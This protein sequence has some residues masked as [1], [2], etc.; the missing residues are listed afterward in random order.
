MRIPGN[1]LQHLKDFFYSEL[2]G[3]YERAEIESMFATAAEYYLGFS[4]TEL[5][6]KAGENLNQSDVLKLYD[7][8]K[9]LKK[10]SPLQYILGSVHFYDTIIQVNS[11]VL[12]PRPETEE[13][14]DIIVKEDPDACN[15]LDLC[16][17]SGCIAIA[18]KKHLPRA[19]VTATDVS[20]EALKTAEDNSLS[21]QVLVYFFQSDLLTTAGLPVNS[22]FDVMVSNPPYVM[23][24]EKKEMSA[25]VL[26]H[27]PHLA[28]FVK[29]DDPLL[30]YKKIIDLCVKYLSPAG[31]L[32]FELNPLT[33]TAVLEYAEKSGQFYE[34]RLITDMSGKQRFFKAIKNSS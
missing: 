15:I 10:G 19:S 5:V 34:T 16:T 29:G 31:R 6:T 23:E 12:I 11:S 9:A 4:R 18:L 32:Y 24:S 30:F 21:N 14:C 22:S 2:S 33:A 13:L 7:C 26:N 8:A 3:I 17:G 20:L 25:H 28:L 27:E 1:K